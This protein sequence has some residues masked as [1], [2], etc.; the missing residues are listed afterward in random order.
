MSECHRPCQAPDRPYPAG[1]AQAITALRSS[2]VERA[3]VH[4][5]VA[6]TGRGPGLRMALLNTPE[7]P[8]RAVLHPT[9]ADAVS[10]SMVDSAIRAIRA[11][12][13]CGAITTPALT[14]EETI[15]FRRA[16][17]EEVAALLLYRMDLAADETRS[18]GVTG[19]RLTQ[20]PRR[21]SRADAWI[22]AALS[23]D[24]AAFRPGEQFD[25]LSI[26]E[27]LHATPRRLVRFAVAATRSQDILPTH[28]V[29]YAVTGRAGRRSYLQRLAVHP[30]YEGRGIASLLCADAIGW[31]RAG[32]ASVLAVN[33]RVDNTRAASL[34][35]RIGFETVPGGLVVLGVPPIPDPSDPGSRPT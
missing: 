15:G 16:G 24:H 29:G 17:F 1:M 9:S 10:D 7:R 6:G 26:D 20:L 2:A 32:R 27:A 25:E 13:H 12:G 3:V 21:R 8:G 23:V 18:A 30:C 14:P 19:I 31:A 35:E 22:R 28:V 5:I 34:Y 33:T 11:A 4:Q